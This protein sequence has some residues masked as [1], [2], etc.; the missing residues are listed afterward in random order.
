MASFRADNP[1]G[2]HGSHHYD[3]ADYGLS[4]DEVRERFAAYVECFQIPTA[5]AR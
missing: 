1:P 3:L 4:A 2:K 5:S